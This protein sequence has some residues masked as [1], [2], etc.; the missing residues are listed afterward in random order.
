MTVQSRFLRIWIKEDG[1]MLKSLL[2]NSSRSG[3]RF[4]P[5]AMHISTQ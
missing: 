5:L 2:D 3:L 4:C 1:L